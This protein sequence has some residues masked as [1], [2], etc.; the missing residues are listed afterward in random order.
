MK[1][2]IAKRYF[3]LTLLIKV[4]NN[5]DPIILPRAYKAVKQLYSKSIIPND[6]LT[7]VAPEDMIPDEIATLIQTIQILNHK[8]HLSLLDKTGRGYGLNYVKNKCYD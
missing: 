6:A 3:R 8:H 4:T 7:V 1:I 2:A 5:S